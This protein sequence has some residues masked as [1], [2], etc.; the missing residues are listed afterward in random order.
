MTDCTVMVQAYGN[1]YIRH[2]CLPQ[3][4][5]PVYLIVLIGIALLAMGV[6]CWML[7]RE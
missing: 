3:T 6:L 4:G 1:D 5:T 7:A 2:N